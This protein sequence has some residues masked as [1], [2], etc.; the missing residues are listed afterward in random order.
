[1]AARAS[2][3]GEEEVKVLLAI[4]GDKKVQKE[5]D[6]PKRKPLL[7]Q[8]IAQKLQEHGYNRDAEQCKIKITKL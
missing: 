8:K 4:L 6:G 1:M 5:L 7:Y 3:W 2:T